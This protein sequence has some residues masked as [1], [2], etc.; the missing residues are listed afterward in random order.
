MF[1]VGDRSIP[2]DGN[3]VSMID[4]MDKIIAETEKSVERTTFL[5]PVLKQANVVDAGAYGILEIIIGA[6]KAFMEIGS[7]NNEL[8]KKIDNPGKNRKI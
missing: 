1:Q 4:L 6:R 3:G 8:G 7:I 2:S 5:L